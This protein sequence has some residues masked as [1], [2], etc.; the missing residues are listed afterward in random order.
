MCLR[1][2]VGALANLP[3]PPVGSLSPSRA[4]WPWSLEIHSPPTRPASLPSLCL[5]SLS[6]ESER[7]I[8][9][10]LP[11]LARLDKSTLRT[12]LLVERNSCHFLKIPCSSLALPYCSSLFP[13]S[14]KAMIKWAPDWEAADLSDLGGASPCSGLLFSYPHLETVGLDN[15]SSWPFSSGVLWSEC[16]YFS[17]LI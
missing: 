16:S 12:S 9:S 11:E 17:W 3:L 7:S 6:S 15:T 13:L 2:L 14:T 10:L 1:S 5:W 8:Y 4:D